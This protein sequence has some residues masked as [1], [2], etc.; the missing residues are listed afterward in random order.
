[1][2]KRQTVLQRLEQ[3]E[4]LNSLFT[5]ELENT[6]SRLITIAGT[7]RDAMTRLALDGEVNRLQA[8]VDEDG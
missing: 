3:L 2:S 4:D 5:K 8:L 1:M 7:T 6:I